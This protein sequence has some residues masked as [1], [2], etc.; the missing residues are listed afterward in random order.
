MYCRVDCQLEVESKCTL[1]PEDVTNVTLEGG[2]EES[3]QESLVSA[4]I[5]EGRIY[6]HKTIS[7]GFYPL[8][9]GL[10]F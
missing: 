9:C 8:T 1:L 6:T 3:E 7:L 4:E 10:P 5:T 2:R